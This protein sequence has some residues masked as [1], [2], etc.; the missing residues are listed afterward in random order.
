M[1][2]YKERIPR[3]WLEGGSRKWASY[4]EILE[5]CWRHF[6]GIITEKRHNFDPS[7]PPAGAENLHVKWRNQEGPWAASRQRPEGLGRH[8]QDEL[9]STV[10]LP[11][12]SLGQSSIAPWT[13]WPPPGEKWEIE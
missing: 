4:S 11:Q 7:T 3:W 1:K 5:R 12:T 8:G 13:D 6:A 2:S 9:R 10:V